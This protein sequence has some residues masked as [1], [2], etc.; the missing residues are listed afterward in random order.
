VLKAIWRAAPAVSSPTACVVRS[1]TL[2]RIAGVIPFGAE[3]VGAGISLPDRL[4]GQASS[5][6]T[7]LYVQLAPKVSGG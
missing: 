1:L 2:I 5:R 6:T 7:M 4:M 3:M